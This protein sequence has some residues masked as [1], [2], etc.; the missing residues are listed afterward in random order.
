MTRSGNLVTSGVTEGVRSLG[1]RRGGRPGGV[2]PALVGVR[3]GGPGTG[4]TRRE[5]V[6]LPPGPRLTLCR[7][8]SGATTSGPHDWVGSLPTGL[9]SLS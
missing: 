6:V 9:P 1:L 4:D 5:F 7:S 3:E 8:I 2:A